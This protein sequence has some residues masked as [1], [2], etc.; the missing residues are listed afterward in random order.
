MKISLNWL[1]ELVELPPG[2]DAE[3]VAAALTGQGLEVEG[4]E[5]KGRELSGVVVAEVLDIR[6]HPK[7]DKLRIVRVR[8]GTREEDVCRSL[9]HLARGRAER[10][11]LL[12]AAR[13]HK[14]GERREGVAGEVGVGESRLLEMPRSAVDAP[15]RAVG[16][17]HQPGRVGPRVLAVGVDGRAAADEAVGGGLPVGVAEVGRL[18][19]KWVLN[20]NFSQSQKSDVRIIVTGTE[21]GIVMVEGA[22]NEISEA[23]M[24]D[25]DWETGKIRINGDSFESF[26]EAVF[27][28]PFFRG[29]D[30]RKKLLLIPENILIKNRFVNIG[31]SIYFFIYKLYINF[32]STVSGMYLNPYCKCFPEYSHYF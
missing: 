2:T 6:P 11:A 21:E 18:D 8:A 32:S 23:E 19:G 31:Q 17:A 25:V 24:V 12:D 5:A 13:L 29:G 26:K 30:V 14:V 10:P 9:H 22:S 16:V 27:F 7:A 15:G 20:P 28:I 3:R 4:I 1:R